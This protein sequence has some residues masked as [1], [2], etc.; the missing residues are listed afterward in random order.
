MVQIGAPLVAQYFSQP[1]RHLEIQTN[2]AFPLAALEV[3]VVVGK[4]SVRR[5]VEVESA[6]AGLDAAPLR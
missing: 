6:E 3:M 4:H 5:P 1:P 2:L